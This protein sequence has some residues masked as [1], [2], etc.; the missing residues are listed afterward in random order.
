[1][2]KWNEKD[3]IKKNKLA[4]GGE[5][6]EKKGEELGKTIKSLYCTSSVCLT[7]LFEGSY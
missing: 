6:G 1:M 7:V 5:G 2:R 4:K 3:N